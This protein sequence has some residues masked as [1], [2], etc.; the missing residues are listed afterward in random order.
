MSREWE[1]RHA[2]IYDGFG[3][4]TYIGTRADI[5]ANLST[6]Y[7]SHMN[8]I[9]DSMSCSKRALELNP[10]QPRANLNLGA[11]LVMTG[12]S[13]EA[14]VYLERAIETSPIAGIREDARRWLRRLD[15]Q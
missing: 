9:E 1:S 10:N 12:S 3:R 5:W 15:E 6:V 11:A 8:R 7:L 4:L 2:L 14:R 13:E